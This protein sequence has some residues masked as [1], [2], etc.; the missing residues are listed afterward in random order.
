MDLLNSITSETH[1]SLDTNIFIYALQENSPQAISAQLLLQHIEIH[2]PTVTISVL[3]MLEFLI[4]VYKKQLEKE[5]VMY[6]EFL[7]ANGL[8]SVI[9]ITPDVARIAAS[10][11]A[12]HQSMRTPDALHI[13][14]ASVSGATAFV[15]EDNRLP[16]KVAGVQICRL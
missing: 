4:G 11:R 15:T 16:H 7:T 5:L 13:A 10:I 1:L 14:C 3:V 12:N 6:E 8:F 2:K 9:N